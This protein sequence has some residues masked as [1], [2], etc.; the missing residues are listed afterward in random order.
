MK[1]SKFRNRSGKR[2]FYKRELSL[3]DA[4]CD[5]CGKDCQVPFKPSRDKPIYCSDCFEKRGGKEGRP[6]QRR[7]KGRPFGKR[8]QSRPQN[9][10]DT[11][12]LKLTEEIKTLNLK[13][14]A[15]I[16][17]LSTKEKKSSS[18]KK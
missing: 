13:L 10:N 16:N 6:G 2:D 12:T 3:Y 9:K 5:Q 15:I 7:S 8:E 1:N 17:L 18:A 14:D 4:V 11:A